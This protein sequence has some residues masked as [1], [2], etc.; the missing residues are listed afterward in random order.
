MKFLVLKILCSQVADV[1]ACGSGRKR[2]KTALINSS[3]VLSLLDDVAAAGSGREQKKTTRK[4]DEEIELFRTATRSV[5]PP[6]TTRVLKSE[7]TR[8][9]QLPFFLVDK[10]RVV[11]RYLEDRQITYPMDQ[12]EKQT[13]LLREIFPCSAAVHCKISRDARRT[14]GYRSK[15]ASALQQGK[16]VT[17][18]SRRPRS[19]GHPSTPPTERIRK[20]RWKA[21]GTLVDKDVKSVE[22]EM[23]DVCPD[24]LQDVSNKLLGRVVPKIVFLMLVRLVAT[25]RNCLRESVKRDLTDVVVSVSSN[26][27]SLLDSLPGSSIVILDGKQE[28]GCALRS[29]NIADVEGCRLLVLLNYNF[30]ETSGVAN[31][32][33]GD[34]SI[35][36][37]LRTTQAP[38]IDECCVLH[39]KIPE[40]MHV[41]L[42]FFKNSNQPSN[43]SS[44][45][46]EMC[47]CDL[48]FS[49]VIVGAEF[50][51]L[52]KLLGAEQA[53][54][55]VAQLSAE[56]DFVLDSILRNIA[57]FKKISLMVTNAEHKSA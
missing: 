47:R 39:E 17:S 48:R 14:L 37:L 8:D 54:S 40:S 10:V 34:P 50:D 25:N 42:F 45:V 11:R 20:K 56:N 26:Y 2:K 51:E 53:I 12:V 46:G 35:R 23:K 55:V 52:Y 21:I 43:A 7:T 38:L 28:V 3:Q 36:F 4:I 29:L 19:S 27:R 6:A 41:A 44:L 1:S 31:E 16:E 5:A 18:E 22:S 30:V 13:V 24:L 15:L 32:L 33:F 49:D 9:V 57:S